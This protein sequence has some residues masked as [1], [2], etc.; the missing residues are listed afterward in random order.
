M[1]IKAFPTDVSNGMDLRDYFAAK[2]MQSCMINNPEFHPYD[3]A[4]ISYS[5]ADYMIR[6]KEENYFFKGENK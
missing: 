6:T 5:L 3:I 1:N 4:R 2:A